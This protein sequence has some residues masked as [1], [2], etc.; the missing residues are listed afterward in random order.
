MI[1]NDDWVGGQDETWILDRTTKSKITGRPTTAS[2]NADSIR[3]W[4][5]TRMFANQ[6]LKDYGFGKYSTADMVLQKKSEDLKGLFQY[7]NANNNGTIPISQNFFLPY[8]LA[9]NW[10]FVTGEMADVSDSPV[11]QKILKLIKQ[12]EEL[13]IKTSR[14]LNNWPGLCNFF[15]VKGDYQ[16]LCRLNEEI[17]NLLQDIIQQHRVKGDYKRTSTNLIDKFLEK[18]DE[19]EETPDKRD[20][21]DLIFTD[22]ALISILFNLLFPSTLVLQSTL[23]Y[24]CY[25]LSQ[26][27]Y[28]QGKLRE[29]VLK[30]NPRNSDG[31]TPTDFSKYGIIKHLI[32][33]YF[34]T[35]NFLKQTATKVFL[36]C[37]RMPY[38]AAFILEVYRLGNVIPVEKRKMLKTVREGDTRVIRGMTLVIN[39]DSANFDETLW[40]QPSNFN[41]ERYLDLAGTIVDEHK[42]LAPVAGTN[43]LYFSLVF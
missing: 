9:V 20:S 25:F 1:R 15:P 18:I 7:W 10:T 22:N 34:H 17:R 6:V 21:A 42:L 12:W 13:S 14:Y 36:E 31:L 43:V 27:L 33:V 24:A 4:A 28:I 16:R 35:N 37:F 3:T 30:M 32:K 40:N 23:N 26:H 38:L 29:E 8:I 39:Y 11:L 19:R 5:S 2:E 41:P